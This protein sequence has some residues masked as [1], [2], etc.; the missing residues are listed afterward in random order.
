MIGEETGAEIGIMGVGSKLL[1]PW[2]FTLTCIFCLDIRC[3]SVGRVGG[4]SYA[5][6]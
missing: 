1:V 3:W 5:S 2:A 6:T 4:V